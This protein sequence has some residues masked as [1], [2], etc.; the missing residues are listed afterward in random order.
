MCKHNDGDFRQG[1]IGIIMLDTNFPRI[2]GDIGNPDSFTHSTIYK[3]VSGASVSNVVRRDGAVSETKESIIK[4]AIEL[5][6]EG[7]DIIVTSCGFL[8]EIQKELQEF[9]KVPVLTSS[10]I[11][12]PF[13]QSVVGGSQGISVLTFDSKKLNKKHLNIYG[14]ERLNIFG[15]EG[16][17]ELYS[18]IAHD[19]VVL[20]SNKAEREVIQAV[21]EMM[22]QH[23]DTK[24]LILECTNLSPYKSAIR[25]EIKI[26]VFDLV[27]TIEWLLTAKYGS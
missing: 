8:S 7:V 11:L 25:K 1:V 6:G 18:V 27:Q 3:R 14:S 16:S 20:D 13:V 15:I 10:L 19:K 26:P 21:R 23:P 12:V 22:M 2:R 24:A 5:E 17:E 4:A 9:V